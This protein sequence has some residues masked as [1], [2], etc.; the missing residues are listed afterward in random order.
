M[1]APG[2]PNFN[3]PQGRDPKID[4]IKFKMVPDADTKVEAPMGKVATSNAPESSPEKNAAEEAALLAESLKKGGNY[5]RGGEDARLAI[6]ALIL[7]D[8]QGTVVL[9]DTEGEIT[10]EQQLILDRIYKKV[11]RVEKGLV[12]RAKEAGA[13]ALNNVRKIDEVWKKVSPKQKL[14]ISGIL[15]LSGLGSVAIGSAIAVGG[16]TAASLTLRGL[17]MISLFGTFERMLVSGHQKKTDVPRSDAEIKRHAIM[18]GALALALGALMPKALSDFIGSEGLPLTPGSAVTTEAPIV[19]LIPQPTSK[20]EFVVEKGDTL[21]GGIETKLSAQGLFAGMEAGQKTY[22]LDALKDKFAAMSPKELVDIGFSSGNIDLVHPGDTIDLTKVL[23]DAQLLPNVLHQAEMLSPE[24]ISSIENPK[25]INV[26]SDALAS[27]FVPTDT[28]AS[29]AVPADALAA[30]GESASEKLIPPEAMRIPNEVMVQAVAHA[31][32]SDINELF[33][34]KGIFGFFTQNGVDSINWKDPE[35][36]FASQSV[37]KVLATHAFPATGDSG[38]QF[39]IENYSGTVKMQEYLSKLIKTTG[40][41]PQL[42]ESIQSYIS[43]VITVDGDLIEKI[44]SSK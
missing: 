10:P 20:I 18:A 6:E 42:T 26:P 7:R 15:I 24:Q 27:P 11:D 33:G 30:P 40:I 39:G 41:N 23:G 25:T 12:A 37:D 17:G 34:S 36:G 38:Q 13:E 2:Q 22:V 16:V 35:V 3:A 32:R 4:D 31:L 8:E 29:F 1:K 43:R 21:W 14:A 9:S 5:A 28:P 19:E 44:M